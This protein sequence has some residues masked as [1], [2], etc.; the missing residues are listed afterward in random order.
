MYKKVL[1]AINEHINSE[2]A[3]RYAL[4]FARACNARLILSFIAEKDIPVSTIEKAQDA[5]KRLIIEAELLDIPVEGITETGEIVKE[6]ERIVNLERVNIVFAATRREDVEKR[7]YAGTIARHLSLRL[8]CSVALVRVVHMG[9]VH[10]KNILVPLKARIDHVKERAYFI[11]KMAEAF[12]SRVSIFHVTRPITRFFHGEI[13]LTPAQWENRLPE[14][15]RRFMECLSKK[16]ILYEGRL[17]PG[18][19]AKTIS[20]E[21]ASKRHDLII[22]GASE[23]SLFSSILKGNPVEEL[24][25]ETPCD[26]IILKPRDG[27]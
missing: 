27:G 6:I 8:P 4:N 2:V 14:D 9:R 18:S 16:E 19:T 23:R 13:H 7:F 21:A 5:M 26:L 1:A 12:R 20:I 3:G 17:K 22:M 15:I 10:P 11:A 25:R 24:L